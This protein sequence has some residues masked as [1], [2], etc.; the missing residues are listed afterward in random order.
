MMLV[1]TFKWFIY[2]HFSNRHAAGWT[3]CRQCQL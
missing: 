1:N 3:S 2:F